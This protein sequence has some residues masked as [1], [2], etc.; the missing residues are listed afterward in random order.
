MEVNS[1]LYT[2]TALP[3][4]GEGSSDTH[5]IGGL[6]GLRTGLDVLEKRKIT[7]VGESNSSVLTE[8]S[9]LILVTGLRWIWVPW[10]SDGA[11][12]PAPDDRWVWNFVG[13]INGGGKPKC[14]QTESQ[15]SVS[16]LTTNRTWIPLIL[17]SGYRGEKPLPN[18]LSCGIT[19]DSNTKSFNKDRLDF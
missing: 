9:R 10:Y 2:P 12:V 19:S 5:W 3:L 7:S 14:L 11:F 17:N 6:L 1:E 15:P 13:M 8:L 16:S 4:P 18:R